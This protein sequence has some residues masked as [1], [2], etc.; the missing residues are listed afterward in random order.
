MPSQVLLGLDFGTTNS[1][2]AINRDGKVEIVDVD[3]FNPNGKTMRSVLF[4]DEEKNVYVGYEAIAKYVEEISYGRYMQSIK[5]FLSDKTFESTEIYGKTYEIEDLVAI[6]LRKIRARGEEYAGESVEDVVLGRP[7]VFSEDPQKDVFAE[8][9]LKAAAEKAGF[10][11]IFFQLEPIAAALAFESSLKSGEEKVVLVGDFGGGTSD[12]TVITL[13]GG[14][15][16]SRVDRK[17]DILSVGGVYIGGDTFDSRMMWEKVAPYF[18]R[19]VQIKFVMEDY[20]HSMPPL[21]NKLRSWHLIPQL[22]DRNT[23]ESIRKLKALADRKDL[24]ENLENLIDDNYGFMLFQAIEKAKCELSS[25]EET[26]IFYK[27]FSL[28]IR[29]QVARLEFE[30]MIREDVEKIRMCI[31]NVLKNAGANADDIDIVFL[32]G[33]SSNIPY[34]KKI[35]E[36]MFGQSKIRRTDVFTSVA[37]GLGISASMY[38]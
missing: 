2:L 26:L 22:R 33:G 36:E 7:V 30:D 37:Y 10:K 19:D 20:W 11:N 21:I 8:S 25:Q 35:F 6:I 4:F 12:F 31:K 27:E 3:E 23:R 9:R 13:R 16:Q 28:I 29:E 5:A 18:G 1:A 14:K 32:T 38:L 24:I 15:T 17:G 34:I